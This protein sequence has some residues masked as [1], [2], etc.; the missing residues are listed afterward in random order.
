MR[1]SGV[2]VPLSTSSCLPLFLII[3]LV[4]FAYCDSPSNSAGWMICPSGH[5]SFESK[6][7]EGSSIQSKDSE[8]DSVGSGTQVY[9]Q[10]HL[11]EEIL[12]LE[13]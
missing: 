10:K 4:S 2:C 12:D 11:L 3:M 8:S 6:D 1:K 9:L 7:F 13:G 5:M